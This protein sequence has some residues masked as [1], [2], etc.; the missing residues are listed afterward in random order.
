[1]VWG[2]GLYCGGEGFRSAGW[3]VFGG[4]FVRPPPRK[5]VC[6]PHRRVGRCFALPTLL[7][8]LFGLRRGPCRRDSAKEG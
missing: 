6:N 5:P 2:R 8:G 1:M 7:G 3:P 4:G